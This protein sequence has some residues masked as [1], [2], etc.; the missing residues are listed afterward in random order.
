MHP[1]KNNI[2]V[3]N[4]E[5]HVRLK[6]TNPKTHNK[7]IRYYRAYTALCNLVSEASYTLNTLD[8][9]QIL[10]RIRGEAEPYAK[11]YPGIL[12]RA[13]NT[14]T[15]E[16]VDHVAG[17]EKLSKPRKYALNN[18]PVTLGDDYTVILY[19]NKRYG[20]ELLLAHRTNVFSKGE[21]F[22]AE[23]VNLPG[24]YSY[25]RRTDWDAIL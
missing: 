1:N 14:V 12:F 3:G 11:K 17:A 5:V 21:Q 8:L 15:R 20:L 16:Y 22:Y 23:W 6:A 2:K 9:N 25:C 18:I 10:P 13:F 4:H 19:D 24:G 7:L